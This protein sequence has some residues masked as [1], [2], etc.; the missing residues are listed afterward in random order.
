M[1]RFFNNY[2]TD[3]F[4]YVA[5]LV[6][7]PNMSSKSSFLSMKALT[8]TPVSTVLVGWPSPVPNGLGGSLTSNRLGLGAEE[9]D[10]DAEEEAGEH[11]VV[12]GVLAVFPSS[13]A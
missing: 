12:P 8:P 1:W 11:V 2:I 10:E 9:D 6:G 4:V 5:C 3:P 7:S 13:V